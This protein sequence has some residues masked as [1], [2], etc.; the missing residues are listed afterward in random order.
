MHDSIII[1][2]RHQIKEVFEGD[3]DTINPAVKNSL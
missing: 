1:V 2:T 3:D